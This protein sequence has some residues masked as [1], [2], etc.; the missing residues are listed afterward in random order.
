MALLLMN[1]MSIRAVPFTDVTSTLTT[2]IVDGISSHSMLLDSYVVLHAAFV[3]A[4]HKIVGVEFGMY[5]M[6][7]GPPRR[8]LSLRD[9]AAY[10]VQN[11]VASYEKHLASAETHFTSESPAAKGQETQEDARGKEAS[12]LL[13]LLS[14]L[15]NFSVISH[16]LMYDLIRILLSEQLNELR[17]EL[18]LKIARDAGQQLRSVDPMALKDIIQIVHTKLPSDPKAMSSRTRFMV[19]TLTNLKNN[20]VKKV[21]VGAAGSAGSEAV[22]RVKKFLSGLNK[23]KHGTYRVVSE[24]LK[25]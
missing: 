15:F 16:V 13:V 8:R 7:H 1:G 10:F 11:V 9:S 5:F 23:K 4:L 25:Y 12:N 3:A 2:L 19:E 22:E 24:Y 21:A 17:V 6:L 18:I 14:E 20:K